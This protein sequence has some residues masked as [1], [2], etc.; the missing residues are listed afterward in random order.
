LGLAKK[1]TYYRVGGTVGVGGLVRGGNYLPL[2]DFC[3]IGSKT[4]SS[5]DFVLPDF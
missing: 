1:V 5:K 3:Q 4:C 2:S